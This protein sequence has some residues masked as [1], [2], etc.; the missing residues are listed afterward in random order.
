ML[1]PSAQMPLRPVTKY[2]RVTLP[3]GMHMNVPHDLSLPPSHVLGGAYPL[4]AGFVP[5]PALSAGPL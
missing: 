4:H 3:N 1:H 2:E 5:H